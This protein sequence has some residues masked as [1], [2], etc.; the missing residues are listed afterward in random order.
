MK[1]RAQAPLALAAA[2]LMLICTSLTMAPLAS[3]ATHARTYDDPLPRAH[4]RLQATAQQTRNQNVRYG[5]GSVMAGT[6]HIYAIF[7][8]PRGNVAPGYNRLLTRFF[9]D[10]GNSPL[11]R[12][13]GEYKQANG[14]APANAVLSGVWMDYRHY[15]GNTILDSDIQHE[16]TRAQRTNGWQSSMHNMFFVFTEAGENICIDGT[17]AQCATNTFCAYHSA[18]GTNTIYASMPYAASFGCENTVG[19]NH[20]AADETIDGASHELMEAVTDP[21]GD[22]W[23]DASGNEIGDKCVAQFGWRNAQGANVVW[24]GHSY[25]VQKEWD[26]QTGTCRLAPRH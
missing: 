23:V 8:E 13:A 5:G 11:Y 12:I 3:A 9:Q 21:L 24:N 26:N 22:A 15:S 4:L 16:V 18:F 25:L 10:V 7:W 1:L 6:T 20:N 19:P 2:L 14:A 17:H